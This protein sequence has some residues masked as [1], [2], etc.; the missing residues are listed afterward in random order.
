S[1]YF[2]AWTITMPPDSP[3]SITGTRI[4]DVRRRYIP[5]LIMAPRGQYDRIWNEFIAEINQIPQRDRDAHTAFLQREIDRR[6]EA[7]GGY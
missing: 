4:G 3:E 1:T 2:P 7:A 6:V 5:Q